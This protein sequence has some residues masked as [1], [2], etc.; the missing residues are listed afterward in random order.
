MSTRNQTLELVMKI[1][2]ALAAECGSLSLDQHIDRAKLSWW[3][4]NNF[5][6]GDWRETFTKIKTTGMRPGPEIIP[7]I[8]KGTCGGG[9]AANL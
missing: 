2:E 3:I 9:N 6:T 7:I 8:T 5:C 4:F 1:D